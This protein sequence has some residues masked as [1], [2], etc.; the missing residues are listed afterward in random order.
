MKKLNALVAAGLFVYLLSTALVALA[1]YQHAGDAERDAKYFL[2]VYGDSVKG[3][4][5]D[6][7][8][9]CHTS[10]TY[11][12]TTLDSCQYCHATTNYG[13]LPA[14][15]VATLN[16]YGKDYL[17]NVNGRSEAGIRAIETNDSD[18][19]KYSNLDEINAI[20]YPG[21]QKDDP[22]KRTANY[23]IYSK[24]QLQAMPQHSQFM[25]M[26]TTKSG[27][28][29]VTYSGVIMQDLLQHAGITADAKEITAI[30]PDGYQITSPLEDSSS[31]IGSVYSAFVYG[32]Y[33]AATYYYDQVA[34]KANGGWCD[35]S[36]PGTAG[37]KQGDPITVDGGLRF[38]L[39][40]QADGK[41]LVPGYLDSSFKLASGTEGPFRTVTPQKLPGPPDQAST[42]SDPTK[43]WP[44]DENLDHN[45]G[46]S[47]KCAT[48]IKV[49]PL[50]DGT[51]DVDTSE[52]GWNYIAQEKIV[53]YGA[54]Q[55]PT[56]TYPA[57]G[58]GNLPWNP[59]TFTWTQV[60]DTDPAAKV[61]YIVE[62]SKDQKTWTTVATQVASA[63][64]SMKTLFA[65]SGNYKFLFFGLF[66]VIAVGA[67]RRGKKFLGVLF[68]I[69]ATSAFISSCD[70][71]D[72]SSGSVSS[73]TLSAS[74]TLEPATT[75][76]WRV[77]AD[78]PNSHVI[79]SVSSFT[80]IK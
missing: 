61:T 24:T 12:K 7:C 57:N 3:T 40:L 15:F 31:N 4:K 54:L 66:G 30:S 25:L 80:T 62:I 46:F 53:I 28:Y 51:T 56:L 45:A 71:G 52:A 23:R 13:Q 55:G 64:K 26:N 72:G 33:S 47:S 5:L 78:G 36:S 16:S 49:G 19:D 37:R 17:N 44:F 67:S 8:V 58:A 50:P 22:S 73:D 43:I 6:N 32:A 14:Q 77:T 63:E 65:Q 75:Y 21:N 38:I 39:A 2:N 68:L 27:D 1:A 41:D 20:R 74:T 79:S 10:G 48:I 9:L 35:Y 69:A 59:A 60:E 70:G 42:S 76:Y 34:D 29:Y 18:G 11:N